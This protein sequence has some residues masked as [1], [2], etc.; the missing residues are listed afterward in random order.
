MSEPT[1]DDLMADTA[2]LLAADKA[3]D[4]EAFLDVLHAAF[5]RGDSY[6]FALAGGLA[7]VA[8]HLLKRAAGA[9]AQAGDWVPVVVD[10]RTGLQI[11]PES[12]GPD[13]TF[14]ARFIAAACNGDEELKA[15]LWLALVAPED[16]EP[17]ALAVVMLARV[18]V[19]IMRAGRVGAS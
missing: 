11:N 5:Q 2:Q 7:N 12:A 13:A 1:A 4:D 17:A 10:W 15:D 6:T 3:G 8:A 16:P 14:V 19:A 9:T 18:A